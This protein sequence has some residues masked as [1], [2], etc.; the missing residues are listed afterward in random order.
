[1]I[2]TVETHERPYNS[3]PWKKNILRMNAKTFNQFLNLIFIT[4]ECNR[5]QKGK[6]VGDPQY[7]LT[8]NSSLRH[9]ACRITAIEENQRL[10]YN[11]GTK[12]TS[13][14]NAAFKKRLETVSG[15]NLDVME[16]IENNAMAA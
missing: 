2:Y 11:Y 3:T 1:M 14:I 4:V 5:D 12:E 16:K 9:T 13:Y 8:F 15:L 6:L 7:A 10:L